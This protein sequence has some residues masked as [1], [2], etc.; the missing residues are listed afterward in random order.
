M[1][2]R[3]CH[4]TKFAVLQAVASQKPLADRAIISD[5]WTRTAPLRLA[6]SVMSSRPCV[7]TRRAPGASPPVVPLG[8]CNNVG[9][10]STG[11]G[12]W[13]RYDHQAT[14][15]TSVSCRL[16]SATPLICTYAARRP[17]AIPMRSW[18][19]RYRLIWLPVCTRRAA[20]RACADFSVAVHAALLEARRRDCVA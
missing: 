8:V 15:A 17:L 9:M 12:A 1:P 14:R 2:D 13:T 7:L 19:W 10:C 18:R 5:L 4:A 6:S 16:L 11:F 3:H 20:C